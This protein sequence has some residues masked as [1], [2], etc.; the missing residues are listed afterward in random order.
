MVFVAIV[1]VAAVVVETVLLVSM[2]TLL[3]NTSSVLLGVVLGTLRVRHVFQPETTGC[4][5]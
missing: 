2:S 4:L 3:Y 5:A 1:V